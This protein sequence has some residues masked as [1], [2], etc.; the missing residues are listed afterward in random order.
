MADKY[1]TPLRG[2]QIGKV[3]KLSDGDGSWK[4]SSIWKLT[5]LGKVVD[6]AGSSK[7]RGFRLPDDIKPFFRKVNGKGNVD[8]RNRYGL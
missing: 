1:S 2:E 8:L 4:R 3:E 6:V 7:S 5:I